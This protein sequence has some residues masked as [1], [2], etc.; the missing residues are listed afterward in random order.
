MTL[1]ISSL[2]S[3]ILEASS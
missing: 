3:L 2:E 1:F